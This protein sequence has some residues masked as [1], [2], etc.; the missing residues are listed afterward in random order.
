MIKKAHDVV[1]I[2]TILF[3]FTIGLQRDMA[4]F[5]PLERRNLATMRPGTDR[6]AGPLQGARTKT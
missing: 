1:F 5:N 6:R 3:S 2:L 4:A